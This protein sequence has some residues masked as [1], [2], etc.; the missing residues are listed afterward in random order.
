MERCE[1]ESVRT[2]CSI[3]FAYE[4]RSDRLPSLPY[5]LIVHN[6]YGSIRGLNLNRTRSECQHQR[7]LLRNLLRKAS[8]NKT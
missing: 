8:D 5:A 3:G 7:P 1:Q 6:N 4:E 2:T